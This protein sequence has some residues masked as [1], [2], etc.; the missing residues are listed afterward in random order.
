MMTMQK[1]PN[2][3]TY[4]SNLSLAEENTEAIMVTVVSPAINNYKYFF[5]L[6]YCSSYIQGYIKYSDLLLTS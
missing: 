1:N 6:I 2:S 3:F 5:F 4:G